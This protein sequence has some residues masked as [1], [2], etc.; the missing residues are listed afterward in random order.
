[1][2]FVILK[3]L[4]SAGVIALSSELA[5]RSTAFAALLI[6]LPLISILSFIWVYLDSKDTIKVASLSSGTLL[7]VLPSLAFF[8][9]LSSTLRAGLGFWVSLGLSILGTFLAYMV[10]WKVLSY[11]GVRF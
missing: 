11:F 6:S 1:M 2:A 9:I 10:Y 8:L 5:K 4:A 3:I 7:L